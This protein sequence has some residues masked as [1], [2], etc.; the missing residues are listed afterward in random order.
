MFGEKE[1]TTNI[2]YTDPLEKG[3]AY[4]FVQYQNGK[5]NKVFT[6]VNDDISNGKKNTITYFNT[7]E[8]LKK[9]DHIRV[10]LQNI[11][12]SVY[13]YWYSL[14]QGATGDG[15]AASPANPVSNISGGSLGY[16]SAQAVNSKSIVIQ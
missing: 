9:G 1:Y 4:R 12:A 15:S 13:K 14:W 7:D 16:F 5:K 10:E 8:E 6:I 3:N 2:T 11:D